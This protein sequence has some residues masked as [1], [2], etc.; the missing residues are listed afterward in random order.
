ML[1]DKVLSASNHSA[2]HCF[3]PSM[4]YNNTSPKLNSGFV[5]EVPPRGCHVFRSG[6]PTWKRIQLR[7]CIF[8][9]QSATSA[10]FII[11]RSWCLWKP[12]QSYLSDR[13]RRVVLNGTSSSSALVTSGVP[14]GSMLG[15]LFIIS[16]DSLASLSLSPHA[17]LTMYADD[18]CYHKS[19]ATAEDA[20]MV[21]S[22]RH[23]HNCR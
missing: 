4:F 6:T 7:H 15:P 9:S 8:L 5:L 23:Q 21:H 16:I 20:D 18:I 13:I 2:Q 1:T 14:Q 19:I 22:E 11:C 3:R 10:H 12:V 17:S